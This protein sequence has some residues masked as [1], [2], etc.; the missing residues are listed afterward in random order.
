MHQLSVTNKSHYVHVHVYGCVSVCELVC[1]LVLLSGS[2]YSLDGVWGYDVI[3][4]ILKEERSG[5]PGDMVD[6][7]L[8]QLSQGRS[9]ETHSCKHKVRDSYL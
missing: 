8:N 2:R 6:R 4:T 5:L 3:L 7:V 9:T 1:L